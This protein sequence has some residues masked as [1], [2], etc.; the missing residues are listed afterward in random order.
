WRTFATWIALA[1]V[2]SGLILSTTL[3]LTTDVVAMPLLWVVPLGVYLLSFTLAFAENRRAA[4]AISKLAPLILL[5]AVCAVSLEVKRLDLVFAAISI[6]SLFTLSVALHSQLFCRRPEPAQLT[7]FYLTMSV[8]GVL[9]GIFCAL[10]A[11][12]VFNWTYEHLLL[13]IAAAA[14]LAG[15]SPLER[16]QRIWDGSPLARRF[17]LAGAAIAIIIAALAKGSFDLQAPAGV[18]HLALIAILTLGIAAIGNRPLFA[19][20]VTAL[21]LCAGGWEQ[22]ALSATPGKV[23]RSYFGI[24]SI[25][26]KGPDARMLVHGTTLHGVQNLGSPARERMATSYYAPLSGVGLAMAAAEPLFGSN[27]HVDVVGL[28]A[29][30]LACYARPGQR[31]TFYEVDPLVVQIAT[32]PRRFTFLSRCLP[33]APVVLG[34]GRISLERARQGTADILVLDAFSSD[35]IPMH[36]LTREAFDL[37]RRHLGARGLLVVHISNRNLDLEPVIAAAAVAGGWDARLRA[38]R[39]N[40]AERSRNYS[41]SD[42]IALSADSGALGALVARNPSAWRPLRPRPDFAAW[43]DDHASLLPLIRWRR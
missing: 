37:Y 7:L 38:Y 13:L 24:Y 15:R 41:G 6:V 14:L 23:A 12:L 2:P 19:M 21:M 34:D 20:C 22:L 29:G 16:F 43:T 31:W 35:S 39:P 8:G 17:T 26:Q 5:L 1:A 4:D 18:S 27:A 42:W 32:D 30:T 28:G 33:D 11:P 36:L 3:H 25:R 9:G 40:A 10:V